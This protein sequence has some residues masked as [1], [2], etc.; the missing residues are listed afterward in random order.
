VTGG[1]SGLNFEA[2]TPRQR[3]GNILTLLRGRERQIVVY[4]LYSS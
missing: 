3:L 1:K 4:A 2:T